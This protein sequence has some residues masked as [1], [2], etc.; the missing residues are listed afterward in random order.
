MN[1]NKEEYKELRKKAEMKLRDYPYY[2]ISLENPG[3]K[4]ATKWGEVSG[5][6]NSFNSTVENSVLDLD[7]MKG[8]VNVIDCVME[9]LDSSSKRIIE[10]A[11]FR[12]DILREE[13]QA[14]L[15]IDRNRYYR[16][17]KK[18]LEKFMIVF[19]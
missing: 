9:R 16:L 2:L 3:F 6:I 17:K 5:R 14:E 15:M 8:V 10:T 1:I 12:D 18:A 4:G 7:Y 13:V 11:Y 19:R